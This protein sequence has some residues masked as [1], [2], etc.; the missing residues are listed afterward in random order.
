MRVG[1]LE[2]PR[3]VA[4]DW[5]LPST[6]HLTIN[7]RAILDT[8]MCGPPQWIHSSLWGHDFAQHAA[9]VLPFSPINSTV[10]TNFN[11]RFP[12]NLRLASGRYLNWTAVQIVI[13]GHN[14]WVESVAFSPDGT[15]IASGSRGKP[16]I[17][18]YSVSFSP[19]GSRIASGSEDKTVCRWDAAQPFHEYTKLLS[20]A[21]SLDGS[22][23]TH[24]TQESTIVLTNTWNKHFICFSSRLKH[25][26]H[27]PAELLQGACHHSP[28]DSIPFLLGERS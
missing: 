11:A 9:S 16:V 2:V 24:C 12:N 3:Q 7:Y 1:K 25:M 22:C 21:I 14:E 10:A 27:N 6:E 4:D 8:K 23:T 28:G 26:L 19:D 13:S 17:R 15:R 20:S 5:V 18:I